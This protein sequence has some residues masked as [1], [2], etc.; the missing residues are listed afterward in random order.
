M[1]NVLYDFSRDQEH[2]FSGKVLGNGEDSNPLKLAKI[3]GI[4]DFPLGLCNNT[5]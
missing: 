4:W 5:F 1:D 2:K 3:S